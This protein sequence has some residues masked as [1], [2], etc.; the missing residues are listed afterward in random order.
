MRAGMDAYGKQLRCLDWLAG[1]RYDDVCGMLRGSDRV[2]YSRDMLVW[3]V[4][5]YGEVCDVIKEDGRCY[6]RY[7]DVV[8]VLFSDGCVCSDVKKG[9]EYDFYL[10][11][12]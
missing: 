9:D 4:G 7:N 2:E 3:C 11:G 1:I 6:V 8:V 10:G 5:G 12:E